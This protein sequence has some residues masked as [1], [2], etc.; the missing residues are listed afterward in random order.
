MN[1]ERVL[2][3]ADDLEADEKFVF[4]MGSFVDK[5]DDP[6]WYAKYAP[7]ENIPE[8]HCGTACCIA[9]YV[10]L[11]YVDPLTKSWVMAEVAQ[12]YLGLTGEQASELFEVESDDVD[13]TDI[14]RTQAVATLR[15]LAETGEVNWDL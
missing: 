5:L 15:N 13:L 3:L 2:K 7:A 10:S 8:N 1:K 14:T 12:T 9:G 11:V 4:D 6:A